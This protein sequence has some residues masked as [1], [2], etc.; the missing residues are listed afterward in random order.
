MVVEVENSEA[1]LPAFADELARV[2]SLADSE[3]C[4]Q[5]LMDLLWQR[6]TQVIRKPTSHL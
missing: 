5:V 6:G 4:Q 1:K 3:E 2:M